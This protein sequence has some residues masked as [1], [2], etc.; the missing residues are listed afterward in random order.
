MFRTLCLSLLLSL[1]AFAQDWPMS[2]QGAAD[3]RSQPNE[4]HISVA[5]AGALATKW[6]F[7]TGGDVSATP[8]VVNNVIYVP[9]WSGHLYAIDATSGKAIWSHQIAEY[10]GVSGSV[11]RGSPAFYNNALIFGDQIKGSHSG[12]SVIAVDS[13]S[14]S[15]LWIT[16]V[17]PHPAAIISGPAAVVNGVVYIGTSSGEESFANQAGYACCTFRG[18][19]VAL[20]ATTGK[21]LWQTFVMPVGYSGGAIWQEPAVDTTRGLVYVGTGNNYSVPASVEQCEQKNP[22]SA[23]CTPSKDYFD[24][25]LALDIHTGAVKWHQ[26]LYKY[27]VWNQ[28]CNAPKPGVT[29][30][31]PTGPDFDMGGSGPN[32][33]G[34]VVGF[35]QKTGMYWALNAS[36][37]AVVWSTMVG[38]AGRLGGIQWGTASDGKRV[39]VAI[40]NSTHASHKLISGQTITWGS[41]SALDAATGKILWQTADPTSGTLDE[42]SVSVANGVMY[43]GSLDATGHMNALNAST[44]QVLWSFASGGSVLDGPAIS[45]GVLYW[46]S[47]YAKLG[48]TANNKVYAFALSTTGPTTVTV[49]APANNA[50]VTSP[51]HYV[52]SAVAPSCAGGIASMR[53]YSAPGVVAYTVKAAKIDTS[54][55]LAAGAYNTVVQAFDN[56]GGVAKTPIKISVH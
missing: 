52:A 34:N 11:S 26:H 33:L 35:G 28:A 7:E 38:P 16:K 39:Y 2:G 36:T 32:V 53:I 29:C 37:G 50:S 41:W 55:A 46:G 9:D 47:G 3:L 22:N 23:S 21:I 13:T 1:T 56:C 45:N 4:T 15:L 24:S 12:A 14:G 10:D 42:S 31:D 43:A 19:V 49:T 20:D 18:S 6:V 51:V 5:N 30:P 40:G 17:D 54:I 8:T 44:G 25:A 48:G 27:D